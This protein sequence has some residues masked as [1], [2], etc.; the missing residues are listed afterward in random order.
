MSLVCAN[1][2]KK[3][4]NQ[5]NQMIF[6]LFQT[7]SALISV[8]A[9]SVILPDCLKQYITPSVSAKTKPLPAPKPTLRGGCCQVDFSDSAR[10]AAPR[11]CSKLIRPIR[12]A[13][14]LDGQSFFSRLLPSP[15]RSDKSC[16]SHS[17]NDH[18]L[19]GLIAIP[20]KDTTD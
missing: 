5:S 8:L 13:Q 14:S 15:P 1:T 12:N 18:K 10:K 11:L 9:H 3:K 16:Y 17:T 19:G 6:T 20:P 4:K 7:K 2:K